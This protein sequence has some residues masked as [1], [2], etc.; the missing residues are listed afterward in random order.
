MK[1]AAVKQLVERVKIALGA[2]HSNA[3]AAAVVVA[4]DFNLEV[5]E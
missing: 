3:S 1:I 5:L 2:P 4:G